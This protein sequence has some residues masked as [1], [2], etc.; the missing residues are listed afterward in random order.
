MS[1]QKPARSGLSKS[2][3]KNDDEFQ[4]WHAEHVFLG[5]CDVNFN[6]SSPAMEIRAQTL[7][8]SL[9]LYNIRYTRGKHLKNLKATT[10]GKLDDSKTVGRLT[11]NK[12]EQIQWYHGLAFRQNTLK[13]PN[14][15]SH[16]VSVPIAEDDLCLK[17]E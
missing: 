9:D 3:C 16:D 8:R 7:K 1:S 2:K 14:P 15:T 11:E 5:E 4:E 12:I 17:K 10:K 6:G 13:E